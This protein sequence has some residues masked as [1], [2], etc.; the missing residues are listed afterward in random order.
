MQLANTTN[1]TGRRGVFTVKLYRPGCCVAAPHIRGLIG[2]WRTAGLIWARF[3]TDK[4]WATSS[5]RISRAGGGFEEWALSSRLDAW[6]LVASRAIAGFAG[7]KVRA[8][9]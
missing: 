8:F 2:P 3:R 7:A 5:A 4:G 6:A 9:A 1:T